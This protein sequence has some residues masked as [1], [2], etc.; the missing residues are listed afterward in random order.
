[1]LSALV[2]TVYADVT[3]FTGTQVIFAAVCYALQIYCDFSSYSDMAVGAGLLF[4]IRLQ[5]NFDTPYF[6]Q[7]IPEL[8]RRWHISLS[9]WFRD[10]LYFPLG[11]SRR[12]KL[13]TNLNLMIVF[14]V[15]GLW[16]GAGVQYLIWGLLHG[17]YQVVGR[18]VKPLTKPLREKL[19]GSPLALP[20]KWARIG[21]VFLLT[22]IAWVFFRADDLGHALSIL[23]Q[24]T[25]LGGFGG[26]E[27]FGM[28]DAQFWLLGGCLAALFVWDLSY[29]KYDLVERLANG[30]W[31]RY[32]LWTVLLL[33]V[34]CFGAYGTG[35]DASNFVYFQF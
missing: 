11:G 19:D 10:Y 1:V 8:W 13:R 3:A 16:H 17:G 14:A 28:V 5:E 18:L 2:A 26:A 29:K 33:L 27:A 20:A 22:G 21:W 6:A 23:G 4:G 9:S 31:L 32:A 35:Y 34:L 7:S 12:G 25:T 30:I 15:S 24:M